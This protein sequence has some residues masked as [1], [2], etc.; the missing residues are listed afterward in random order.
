LRTAGS[1]V[2][3]LAM[4]RAGSERRGWVTVAAWA[5]VASVALVAAWPGESDAGKCAHGEKCRDL[6]K[7]PNGCCPPPKPSVTP[8]AKP[9]A[10]PQPKPAPTGTQGSCPAGMLSIAAGTFQMGSNSGE[11][12][13]K[14]VHAVSVSAFCME[15]TE[16][17]VKA[18]AAC[19]AAGSCTAARTGGSC[20]AGVS[21]RDDHPINC[22][23]WNQA[24][25]YCAWKGWRLPTEEEW[26][27]GARG[28]DGREYPWGNGAPG[29]QLCWNGQGNTAGKGNRTSTC[30]VGSFN[31]G[32]SPFGL[33]NMAGNVWEWTSSTYMSDYATP[34][35]TGASDPR[36]YRGGGWYYVSPSS[37]RAA[38]RFW[39]DPS[40]RYDG[41]GFR[42]SR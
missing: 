12:D 8:T 6:L 18:Y 28:T 31:A 16:V 2:A 15:K 39:I 4:E 34:R 30:A 26:E 35:P 10:T 3:C 33:L 5:G 14:P 20:N 36:V 1:P 41:L 32:A 27:Y 22:V 13:E 42:C 38:I 9:T 25:A 17:T 24:T 23:D 19:E 11:S 21:G 7:D 40:Y 29:A 37:V